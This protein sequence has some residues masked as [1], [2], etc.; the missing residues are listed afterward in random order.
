M[1]WNSSTVDRQLFD[2]RRAFDSVAAE[3]DGPLGNNKLVQRMRF[4]MWRTL[5]ATFPPGARLLDLGCGTGIDAV[6][7]AARG[8]E[9][10]AVDWAPQMV[11]RTRRR[12][13]AAGLSHRVTTAVIGIH[14]LWRLHGE[15]FDGI[16]SNLGPLNC[17]P[18]LR[19]VAQGCA[20]LLRPGGH[21]IAS[22]IG[23]LCPWELVYYLGRGD[24]RRASVRYARAAVPVS[25]NHQTVWT[26]YYMPREFYRAFADNF[27]LISYRALGLFLPPPY[28]IRVVERWRW[29]GM[30]LGWLDDHLGAWPLLRDAGDHFLIVLARY[31]PKHAK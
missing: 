15:L 8:Y 29:L 16:Y 30:M 26:R 7:L 20:M 5:I 12:V 23:R 19:P 13:V 6:H 21:L 3:Y 2:T 22:V 4:A 11:E 18:D 28:L 24:L 14:E 10:V 25:L 17:V 1:T 27:K 9:V 31:D